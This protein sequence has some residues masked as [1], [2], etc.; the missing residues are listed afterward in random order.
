MKKAFIALAITVGVGTLR[1]ASAT[2]N[3]TAPDH[4]DILLGLKI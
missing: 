1:I 2:A 4:E 3:D